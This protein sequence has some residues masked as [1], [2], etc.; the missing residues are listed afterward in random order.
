VPAAI[1]S[2]DAITLLVNA[3]ETVQ[4]T[5]RV[6]RRFIAVRGHHDFSGIGDGIAREQ[7]WA[8][9]ILIVALASLAGL[10]LG[11]F[12]GGGSTLT[13][14]ILAYGAGMPAGVAIASSLFVV[15]ITS[16]VGLLAHARLGRVRWRIGLVFGGAGMVGAFVGGRLAVLVPDRILL[17]GFA[18]TLAVAAIAMMRRAQPPMPEHR[19]PVSMALV[20][21]V[22]VG[23]MS[24]LVGAGGGFMVVPALVLFGKLAI[25]EAIATSLLVIALQSSAGFVGHL[26]HATIDWPLVIAVAT[27]AAVGAFV[28]ARVGRYISAPALR[29]GFAVLVIAM[30]MVILVRELAR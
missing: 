10:A 11:L 13:V 5:A 16:A 9:F 3:A 23:L 1:A 28:G 6:S 20:Q 27:I 8:V 30:A 21:G 18:L 19:A 22:G 26:A 4:R 2:D 24:G 14:P 25:E 7:A 12:G 17:T 15:A 29:R